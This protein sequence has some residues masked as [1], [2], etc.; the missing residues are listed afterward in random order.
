MGKASISEGEE[1]EELQ[2]MPLAHGAQHACFGCGPANRTGLRLK[3]YVNQEGTVVCHF[4]VPK[5]FEGPPGLT[6]GGVIATLLDEAMSK[7]NRAK[8]VVAMTR[9]MEVEYLRPVP[10]G[11]A[12]RLEG[13]SAGGGGR[14]HRCEAVILDAEGGVLAQGKAVF[15][16][17]DPAKVLKQARA[18]ED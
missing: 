15:I 1:V 4:R 11:T 16:A 8:G 18:A 14:V 9:Q 5:R 12:L 17:V 7:V 2:L 3:F 10:L 6:H 13:R